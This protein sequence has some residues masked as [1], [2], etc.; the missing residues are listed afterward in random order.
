[1]APLS[2][3]GLLRSPRS[4]G[5]IWV[6]P[7]AYIIAAVAGA[8]ILPRLESAYLPSFDNAVAVAPAI[9]FFSAVGSGM[10]AL[11]GVVFAITFVMV[12]FGSAAYSPR[13]AVIFSTN[14]ALYHALG[15][16]AA[17][18]IYSLAALVW[19]D[20]NGSG[21]VPVL[22]AA[23]VVLLLIASMLALIRLIKSVI[24]LQVH[25][26]LQ[27]L[28]TRGRAVI[29]ALFQPSGEGDP[30]TRH[31][32]VPA[33]EEAMQTVFYSGRPLVITHFDLKS[34]LRIATDGNALVVLEC[35]VGDTLVEGTLLMR[36][37][38]PVALAEVA[39]VKTIH[40]GVMRTFEQDPKYPIRLLVD[41]AIRALSS[42]INDPATAVQA[43]DQIEDLLRRL[44]RV[45]LDVG[46]VRDD[47]GV[48]RL[49][50]PMPTWEDYLALSFDEIRHF[51]GGSI[52]VIRRLR[53]ALMGLGDHV[54][55]ESRRDAV[56]RYL[57]HLNLGITRSAFDDQ[58]RQSALQQ[59]R[60]GLGLS[61][62]PAGMR[63]TPHQYESAAK[64][65]VKPDQRSLPQRP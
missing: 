64:V 59:D 52:Q 31:A 35:A 42:A 28:G 24:D 16:F 13:L 26:V 30:F 29:H 53:A 44:G 36:V 40:L 37:H 5:R 41:I 15:M 63:V 22:S 1:M 9:A 38:G 56:R 33:P 27:V 23:L 45:E 11:T 14:P 51:G 47:A 60:Q 48:F 19:T 34:L 10:I 62:A 46:A 65:Q 4:T 39:L 50:L 58:D 25:N 7:A 20:R 43:I 6:V 21:L 8:L 49:I 3:A 2:P 55:S 57:D 18:F 17:T 12:Q 32:D 61:R 54:I